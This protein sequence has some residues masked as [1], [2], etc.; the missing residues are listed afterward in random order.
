MEQRTTRTAE[1]PTT[2]ANE[3]GVVVGVV[4]VVEVLV[5]LA[6]LQSS[7]AQHEKVILNWAATG[8]NASIVRH[9][10]DVVG[11]RAI[12]EASAGAPVQSSARR[13]FIP[14]RR[15]LQVTFPAVH[16]SRDELVTL[17]VN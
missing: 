4:V 6:W 2:W 1:K 11:P 12:T 13:A 5:K 9:S 10:A 17:L 7:V 8:A 15:A 16:R 14:M 3:F